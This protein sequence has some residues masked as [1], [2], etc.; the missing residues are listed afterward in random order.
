[1]AHAAAGMGCGPPTQSCR[2]DV[3]LYAHLCCCC[4][5]Y[6]CAQG[7][8]YKDMLLV[9]DLSAHIPIQQLTNAAYMGGYSIVSM[10]TAAATCSPA[11]HRSAELL[12][13]SWKEHTC[14]LR[15]DL[16]AACCSSTG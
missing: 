2:N 13:E 15:S 4:C 6:P 11:S 12:Q 16:W 5:C 1:M 8:L 14:V 10:R 9:G 3:L 7:K